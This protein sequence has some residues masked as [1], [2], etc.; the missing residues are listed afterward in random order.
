V[1]FSES[2]QETVARCRW[3]LSLKATGGGCCCSDHG[4]DADLDRFRQVGPGGDGF[5]QFGR[6]SRSAWLR[7]GFW[8]KSGG[9]SGAS[10]ASYPLRRASLHLDCRIA[11]PFSGALRFALGC[12]VWH[13]RPGECGR[14]AVLL[15]VPEGGRCGLDHG[16]DTVLSQPVEPFPPRCR[17]RDQ[18]RMHH[19]R[20]ASE[21]TSIAFPSALAVRT[22]G[23]ARYQPG[24]CP[25]RPASA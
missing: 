11:D 2:K 7:A 13:G 23:P 6:Q 18:D 17:T 3:T 20:D 21:P 19:S 25:V 15:K 14:W 24:R 22:I 5:G 1:G 12:L 4:V 9:I 10:A 8:V 16:Q